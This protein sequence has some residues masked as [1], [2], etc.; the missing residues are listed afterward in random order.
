MFIVVESAR[1]AMQSIIARPG[2][3]LLTSLGIVIGVASVIA[4]VS[5]IQ[6]MSYAILKNFDGLGTNVLTIQSDTPFDQQLEGRNNRLTLTDYMLIKRRFQGVGAI[7]PAFPP[8]G[9]FGT[10]VRGNGRTSQT[11]V[12]AVTSG[13][14]DALH[15]YPDSGR[16]IGDADNYS[17]RKI[18]VIGERLRENLHLAKNP[19]GQFIDVG[20]ASFEIVGVMETRGDVFGISQ[21]DYLLMPFSV[22]TRVMTDANRQDITILVDVADAE[23]TP[24]LQARIT[25][26]MREAHKIG[27]G[28]DDD[29][30]VQTPEQL[31]RSVTQ[32]TDIIMVVLG[33]V[34]GISLL[35]GGIGI[36]NIMLVAVTERTREIGICKA[37]GA[38]RHA[39]LLQ[40]MLEAA[41][42]SVLG[43]LVGVG[44]GWAISW[45][46]SLLLPALPEPVVPLWAIL[47]SLG[48]TGGIGLLFGVAPAARAAD[49]D[50]I[51]A[52]RFE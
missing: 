15:V 1:L 37:L 18:C 33:G 6:G 35:V 23:R 49:L 20:G 30:R 44:V 28:Q 17:A 22:G 34:V 21:D 5:V 25:G 7:I 39:I 36:M 4:M 42:L 41:I 46:A 51:E 2:R 52:L 40:F 19:I 26:A 48:F 29:F 24:E 38:P 47:L 31:T 43:G 45:L 8:F 10:S 9:P 12:L 13:Y 32:V 27:R 16:F 50:P 3:S 11:R 14:K